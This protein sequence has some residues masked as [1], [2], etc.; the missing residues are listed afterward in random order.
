MVIFP[1][2]CEQQ[3]RFNPDNKG[4]LVWYTDG[5]RTNKSI[6]A[7]VYRWSLR[8]GQSFSL[9]LHTM[10]FQTEIYALKVCL[11]GWKGLHRQEHLHYF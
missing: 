5:S 3:D 9:R 6:G 2:K 1:H 7:G 11:K 4:S 10:V 8:R